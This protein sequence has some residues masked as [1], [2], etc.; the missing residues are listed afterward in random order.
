MNRLRVYLSRRLSHGFKVHP[1]GPN[2]ARLLFDLAVAFG[3]AVASHLYVALVL[4][5]AIPVDYRLYL[6]VPAFPAANTLF[7]LYS[8]LRQSR[9]RTKAAALIGSILTVSAAEL[10]LGTDVAA[11]VLWAMLVGVAVLV[12][13]VLLGLPHSR[14]GRLGRLATN[15][16]G[17]VLVVGGAGYIGSHTVDLLLKRGQRVRV[18]DKLMYGND[19]LSEFRGNPNF[20]FIEGD[21]TDITKVTAAVKGASAV[22]HLAGLVGDPACAINPEFTRHTNIVATRMAK[23]VA[24][25]LGVSR[26]I[27]ASSCSVYGVSETEVSETAELNPVSLYAQTKIDSERELLGVDADD[28]FVTVLRFATVFGHSRRPRFDLVANFFTA[29]AMTDG[30]ITVTGPR[31]WRPFIHVR[32]LA[33]AIVMCVEADPFLVQSQIYNVGDP[34]LNMTILQLAE[35]VKAS[36]GR[37][38]DVNISVRE[39]VDDRRS[40]AVSFD[41]IQRDL[42]FEASILM[43]DGIQEMVENFLNGRYHHYRDHIY[44]NVATTRSAVEGFYDPEVTATLYAPLKVSAP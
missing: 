5:G 7:G 16:R 21:V 3:A 23:D 1:L 20:E 14:H 28:F 9:I 33:R 19:S 38:R 13:R 15:S 6:L 11:V 27:F 10:A 25:S 37:Y 18:L 8:R 43:Q 30:L 44:S 26:F 31:Q 34:R 36:A 4:K 12:A 22:V 32:D 2:E 17:P 35:L 40:Y 24:C 41:K 42:G 29:Q 39:D